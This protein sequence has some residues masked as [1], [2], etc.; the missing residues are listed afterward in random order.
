MKIRQHPA[1]TAEL[2]EALA[3][4]A[5]RNPHAAEALWRE[6]QHA[7]ALIIAFPL[8]AGARRQALASRSNIVD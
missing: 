6:A 4:Y 1:A 8:A 3:W 7:R 2:D 5:Q